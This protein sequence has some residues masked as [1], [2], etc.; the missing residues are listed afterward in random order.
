MLHES[1][2][3]VGLAQMALMAPATLL[4]LLGGAI[5]D[6]SDC[7][8]VLIR[9][10]LLAMAPPL[11]LAATIAAGITSYPV[12]I[13]YGVVIGTLGAF[14]TPARDALLSRIGHPDLARAIAVATVAQFLC[15]LVGIGLAATA[16]HVGAPALLVLQA[17]LVG[18]GAFT[19]WRLA[20][21][22]PTADVGSSHREAIRD[23]VREAWASP[24]ILP[25][26]VAIAA[27]GVLYVGAFVVII[28][29]L[30]RDVYHGGAAA[31]A[32][33][34][35]CFWGGTIAA[36]LVQVRLG[37]IRRPGRAIMVALA[38]GTGVLAA[39]AIA[40][41]FVLLA[42]LCL[43]WG[44]GGGVTMTQ[45]RTVVQLAAPDSHRA[46]IMAVFQLGLFGGAPVGAV[47]MGY[48]AA[49]V[50]ARASVLIPALAMLLVLAG[51]RLRS[52]LWQQGSAT[53]RPKERL[54]VG[55]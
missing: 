21:A 1:P 20:P 11:A 39:M 53:S 33:L 48:L 13:A 28:P 45:G 47:A 44:L 31:L 17:V 15:Q 46:R 16:G 36:T 12:L 41:P 34:S 54:E 27:V 23:G 51:L 55:A 4:L 40:L 35:V 7:R 6:R 37:A 19:T 10:H 8:A 49:A 18:A 24:V 9:L 3:R 38:L 50:G 5:A 29:L 52:T 30:V 32:T 25:V 42:V 26:V 22:P 2:Q 14:V 43:V